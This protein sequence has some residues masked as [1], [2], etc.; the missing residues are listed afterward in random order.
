MVNSV[1]LWV[2]SDV[3]KNSQNNKKKIMKIPKRK[4]AKRLR[5]VIA[6]SKIL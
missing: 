2:N 4:Q 6:Q 3:K 5:N 1:S